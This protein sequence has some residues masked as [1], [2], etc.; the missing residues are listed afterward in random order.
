MRNLFIVIILLILSVSLYLNWI[1]LKSDQFLIMLVYSL[2]LFEECAVW[3]SDW[4]RLIKT[5][6]PTNK[7]PYLSKKFATCYLSVNIVSFSVSKCDHIKL[8]LLYLS[9]NLF[10]KNFLFLTAEAVLVIASLF[11]SLETCPSRSCCFCFR[12]E[13]SR[14]ISKRS[15][16]LEES[17][18][19]DAQKHGW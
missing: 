12:T 14:E 9:I 18:V 10:T 1:Y 4:P 6:L 8:L 13:I 16:R 15:N 17:D 11:R 3:W 19:K 5:Q 7:V 2:S